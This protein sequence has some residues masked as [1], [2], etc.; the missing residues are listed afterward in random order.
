MADD[1][2]PDP[3]TVGPAIMAWY[4][5][6]DA[7]NGGSE[8][9]ANTLAVAAEVVA[10]RLGATTATSDKAGHTTIKEAQL[11]LRMVA[12]VFG[13]CDLLA[14]DEARLAFKAEL[15]RCRGRPAQSQLMPQ[16]LAWW[17]AAREVEALMAEGDLQK[18]AVG[19]VAKQ[20]GLKDAVVA[21]WCRERRRSL[22]RMSWLSEDTDNSA[23]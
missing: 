16:S 9:A 2:E 13:R 19:K 23:N 4:A 7:L 18:I 14:D 8:N 1:F 22:E 20:L 15:K 5:L 11:L 21:S 12:E 3:D 17:G 10:K 6:H